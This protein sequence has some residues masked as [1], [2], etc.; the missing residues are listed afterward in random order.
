MRISL[1]IL[2]AA[3]VSGCSSN[4]KNIDAAY[5]S[6]LK[7]RQY[8]CA[9]I[10]TEITAIN[11]RTAALDK[12]LRKRAPKNALNMAAGLVLGW[13]AMLLM[14]GGA[15]T[16]TVEYSQLRGERNALLRGRTTCVTNEFASK[17]PAAGGTG[18]QIVSRDPPTTSA[19]M[20]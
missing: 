14:S 15:S 7:Y 12:K 13:P 2:S 9:D 18:T 16:I 19:P 3:L 6:A 20:P 17:A 10:D 1:V 4:P 11:E 5:V 8:S